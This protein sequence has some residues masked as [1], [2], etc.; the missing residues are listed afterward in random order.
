MTENEKIGDRLRKAR[1]GLE[2]GQKEFAEK[3]GFSANAIIS[4]FEKN[5]SV[6]STE[7]LQKI[8]DAFNIDLHWLI[9]GKQSPINELMR[10]NYIKALSLLNTQLHYNISHIYKTIEEFEKILDDI[11]KK[12]KAGDDLTEGEKE[13]LKFYKSH[14]PFQQTILN[15]YLAD[16][17][18]AAKALNDVLGK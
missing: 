8:A 5:K 7:T 17:A 2:L 6:P 1:E 11:E 16:Q 18:W 9:T 4:R 3:I 10:L 12:Q 15:S 14:I 13:D